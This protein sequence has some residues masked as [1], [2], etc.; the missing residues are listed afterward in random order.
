[1][2]VPLQSADEL[3]DGQDLTNDVDQQEVPSLVLPRNHKAKVSVWELARIFELNEWKCDTRQ[4]ILM[5]LYFYTYQFSRD[6]CFTKEQTSAFF[7]IVK[8]THEVCVETPFGNLDQCFQY[9]KDMVLCHAVRR[10]PFS[11]DIFNSDE[12]R[13]I[14]E[15]VINTY[16]RHYKL[17]KYAFT[18]KVTLDLS[19]VFLGEAPSPEES[20]E[21][22]DSVV[23]EST[24]DSETT[25]PHEESKPLMEE[26]KSPEVEAAMTELRRLVREHLSDELKKLRVS[27]E[28]QIKES[29][30]VISKKLEAAEATSQTTNV[31]AAAK[32]PKDKKK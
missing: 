29:E 2:A 12:V 11:I 22:L 3:K 16:F 21:K 9:F 13:K 7:A 32:G 15:Y 20:T 5:D 18:P 25:A 8:K 19:F 28:G 24:E 31:A 17:Y 4:A 30:N 6:N 10:P 27:V 14:C 26:E 1:M 23:N